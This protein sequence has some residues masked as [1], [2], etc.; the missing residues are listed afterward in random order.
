MR[1]YLGTYTRLGG[2]GVALCRLAENAMSMETAVFL[3]NPTYV[4]ANRAGNR[5]FA[6]SSASASGQPGGSAASFAI[7]DGNLTLLSRQDGLGDDPCHLCLSPEEDC[8]YL[9]NYDSGSVSAFPVDGDGRLG[10][11][12]QLVQHRGHSVHPER[13]EGPHAHQ[14]SILPED[15]LLCC[16]DLGLDALL[17]Y[18]RQEATGQLTLHDRFDLPPGYGPRHLAR[19][20]EGLYCLAHELASKVSLLRREGGQWHLLETHSTLPGPCPENTVAAVRVQGN[21]VMVS[22]RGHDSLAV[23]TRKGD[24]LEP[25]GIFPTG[26]RNP[27]DFYPLADGRMLI[28]HQDGAVTLARMDERGITPLSTLDVKGAV[29]ALPMEGETL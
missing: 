9:A 6:V 12:A 29:C 22:N 7:G 18:A 15:G 24:H 4:I 13:Q 14:V 3:E 5:L 28:A 10:P 2:P 16:V 26:D 23:F 20:G 25:A 8:L 1:F 21:R 17:T 27:R 11:C 19:A